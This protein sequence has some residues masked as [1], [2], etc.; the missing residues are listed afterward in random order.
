[1]KEKIFNY[2]IVNS[3]APTEISDDEEKDGFVYALGR[4]HDISPRNDIKIVVGDFNVQ[5]GK[6]AVRFPTVHNYSLHS[7]TNDNGS[8]LIQFAV[9]RNMIIRS[10]LHPRKDIHKITGRSPDGVTFNQTDHLLIDRRH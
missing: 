8:R 6:E 1:M 7:L 2:T 10:T 4:A 9:S 3:Y 5:V